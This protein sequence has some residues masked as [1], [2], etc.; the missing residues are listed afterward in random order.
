MKTIENE[1]ILDA[2]RK[3]LDNKVAAVWDSLKFWETRGT[4]TPEYKTNLRVW[5]ELDNVKKMLNDPV[6]AKSILTIWE[7]YNDRYHGEND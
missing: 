3:Y 6:Y 4:N 2:V 1:Q 7:D 5:A